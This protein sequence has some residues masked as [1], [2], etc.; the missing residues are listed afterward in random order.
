MSL[1]KSGGRIWGYNLNLTLRSTT[2]QSQKHPREKSG[3]D[4][5]SPPRGNA[6]DAHVVNSA[7]FG[8]V[9]AEFTRVVSVHLRS[10]ISSG[11]IL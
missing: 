6:F 8:P 4:D 1:P 11:V 3:V 2:T 9:T 10:S 5:P 7:R